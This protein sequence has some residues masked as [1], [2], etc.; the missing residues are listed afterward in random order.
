M[1]RH[2]LV[3]RMWSKI[4]TQ[5]QHTDCL[6]MWEQFKYFRMT[7]TK[8]KF[9]QEEIKWTPHSGNA[10][11]HL[12]QNLLSYCLLSKNVIIRIHKTIILLVVLYGCETWSLTLME[13]HRLMVF[14][15]RYEVMGGCRQLHNGELR[16]LYSSPNIIRMI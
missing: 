15:N 6:K 9:I 2:C 7:V 14:E 13:E 3:T 5:R 16:D 11:Y 10:C 12:V 8:P 1:V 4:M